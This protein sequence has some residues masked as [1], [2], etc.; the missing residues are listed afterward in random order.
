LLKTSSDS[1]FPTNL[2][3]NKSVVSTISYICNL[4]YAYEIRITIH[5]FSDEKVVVVIKRKK[6]VKYRQEN[7]LPVPVLDMHVFNAFGLVFSDV[8]GATPKKPFSGL[9]ARR[10][11]SESNFIHAMSSPTHST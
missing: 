4:C 11:P 8:P 3:D 5:A 10:R 7:I 9:I 6:D 1:L 2:T